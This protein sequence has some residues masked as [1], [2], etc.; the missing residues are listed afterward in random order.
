MM[1]STIWQAYR[2]TAYTDVWG[3]TEIGMISDVWGLY[4]HKGCLDVWGVQC[5]VYMLLVDS[6][7]RCLEINVSLFPQLVD[8]SP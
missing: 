3:C 5:Y 4:V 8:A 7:S 1:L 2:Y 6:C